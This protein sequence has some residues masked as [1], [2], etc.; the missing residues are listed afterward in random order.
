MGPSF[1]LCDT[2]RYSD[3]AQFTPLRCAA[4]NGKEQMID[5]LLRE[6]HSSVDD[7][8]SLL[9]LASYHGQDSCVKWLI[10]EGA[11][12]NAST[13]LFQDQIDERKSCLDFAIER[14]HW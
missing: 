13:D 3:Q 2:I 11:D 4:M 7:D 14:K 12:I 9:H 10:K 5:C 8:S 6:S 1:A